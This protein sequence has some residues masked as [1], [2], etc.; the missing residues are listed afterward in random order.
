M[1]STSDPGKYRQEE[2]KQTLLTHLC[3]PASGVVRQIV[4]ISQA[5]F[6]EKA[7]PVSQELKRA[8]DN[9]LKNLAETEVCLLFVLRILVFFLFHVEECICI[10]LCVYSEHAY[11]R[12]CVRGFSL[13]PSLSLSSN[14]PTPLLLRASRLLPTIW[15]VGGIYAGSAAGGALC[16]VPQDDAIRAGEGGIAAANGATPTSRA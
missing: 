10:C 13:P 5:Q 12:M 2:E 7:L 3:R 8:Q 1:A 6:Q 14:V 4:Q 9:W 11:T 16:A 15:G